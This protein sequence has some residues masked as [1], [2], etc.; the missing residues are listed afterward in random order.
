MFE[1]TPSP[2]L[3]YKLKFRT[4]PGGG[5]KIMFQEPAAGL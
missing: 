2:V 4:N 1:T 3:I 5:T